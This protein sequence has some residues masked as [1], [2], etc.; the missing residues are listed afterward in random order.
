MR[1]SLHDIQQIESYI[2]GRMSVQENQ[3]FKVRLLINARL[4]EEVEAQKEAYALVKTYG[5]KKLKAEL[6]AVHEKLFTHPEK[7]SFRQ[8]IKNIFTQKK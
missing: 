5:R 3:D 6:N 4:Y 8:L 7:R 2:F 1:K